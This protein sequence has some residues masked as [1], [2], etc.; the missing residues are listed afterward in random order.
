MDTLLDLDIENLKGVLTCVQ[1]VWSTYLLRS[2]IPDLD[3]K[4]PKEMTTDANG[5]KSKFVL[6]P[7]ISKMRHLIDRNPRYFLNV[8]WTETSPAAAKGREIL[9]EKLSAALTT[10]TVFT[11]KEFLAFGIVD[12]C[13]D[14]FIKVAGGGGEVADSYFKFNDCLDDFTRNLESLGILGERRRANRHIHKKAGFDL[15]LWGPSGSYGHWVWMCTTLKVFVSQKTYANGVEEKFLLSTGAKTFGDVKKVQDWMQGFSIDKDGTSACSEDIEILRA[16]AAKS[17]QDVSPV[18]LGRDNL[19]TP[20]APHQLVFA[21]ENEAHRD[22]TA[23]SVFGP[24]ISPISFE[25]PAAASRVVDDARPSALPSRKPGRL[26]PLPQKML[27]AQEKKQKNEEKQR[28]KKEEEGKYLIFFR[29]EGFDEVRSERWD[30]NLN[31]LLI[32]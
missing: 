17:F 6:A 14:D 25:S 18:S 22:S 28:K 8:S 21:F 9:N 4:I 20:P 3:I 31:K 2:M 27:E 16:S 15:Y 32:S 19:V 23:Q 12:L 5:S 26:K 29:E 7:S 1:T 24:K 11:E 13:E 10:Q 30:S